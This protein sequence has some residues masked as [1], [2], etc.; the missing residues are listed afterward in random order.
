M[1]K[2]FAETMINDT[3]VV[4][5]RTTTEAVSDMKP[6]LSLLSSV[7]FGTEKSV[8]RQSPLKERFTVHSAVIVFPKH[9]HYHSK[10][11]ENQK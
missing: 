6:F 5:A 7:L 8:L 2:M 1:V 10:D 4:K 11:G 9:V 3:T